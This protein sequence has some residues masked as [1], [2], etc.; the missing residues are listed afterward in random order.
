MIHDVK[1]NP[2]QCGGCGSCEETCSAI[3]KMTY[4]VHADAHGKNF[5]KHQKKMLSAYY[6]CPMNAIELVSDDPSLQIAW[7]PATII[8]K[9][10][11]CETV[12]EVKLKTVE[13]KFK[14]GQ[15]I[16]VRF[17]DDIGYFNRAYSVVDI[18]EGIVTLCITLLKGGRGSSCFANYEVGSEV[19]LT[20]PKGDFF[21]QETDN[22]KVFVGTGTGLVPLISMIES[23]RPEVKKTLYFGQRVEKDL[24]YLDRLEKVPNLEVLICL[25]GAGDE[26]DGFHGR[27]TERILS[28]PLTK[29]TEVYTCGSEPMMNGLQEVLKK[30]RHPKK[31]FFKESFTNASGMME[32]SGLARRI[33]TRNIHVYGSLLLSVLFLFFGLSGF[34]A[35][36][37]E[38]FGMQDGKAIPENI[39]LEQNE[40]SGYL[41]SQL[42]GSVTLAECSI[43][44]GF[45]EIQFKDEAD[46]QYN[47]EISLPDR[48]YTV[49]ESHPIPAGMAS[50]DAL[51]LGKKIEPTVPGK[52]DPNS[53]ETDGDIIW[54][55]MESVW[56]NTAIEVDRSKNR[57]TVSK[58]KNPVSAVMVQ[59][60]RGK[61]SSPFQ[62]VILDITAI[63]MVIV[64][65]TGILLGVQSRNPVMRNTAWILIVISVLLSYLM[66]M[67]R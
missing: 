59:M 60:H 37:P 5:E 64:T 38:M 16:T 53:V 29:D 26:W 33:W 6:G 35:S 58:E 55:N 12:V 34:L 4:R 10:M 50:A 27:V 15:Y 39:K 48:D 31:M 65:L 20:D 21:L 7:Y 67:H 32:E 42:P 3:F 17:K 14:P 41:K 43:E 66:M 57:Y 8:S 40:L 36:R 49:I 46:V 9:T 1:V 62:R 18:K 63:F 30:K 2:D 51:E 56:G 24:F 61:K 52:L 22:P 11:L 54:L 45:A 19:E 47:V 13:M 23:S 28:Y 25:D 44:E